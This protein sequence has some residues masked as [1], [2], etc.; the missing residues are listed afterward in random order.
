MVIEIFTVM[1]RITGLTYETANYQAI[2]L[3]TSCGFTTCE[4]ETILATKHRRRVA[5][6]A[7]LFGYMFSVVLATSIINVIMSITRYTDDGDIYS[8]FFLIFIPVFFITIFKLKRLKSKIDNLIKKIVESLFRK[9][10]LVNPFYILETY[11]DQ[12]ICELYVTHVPD[13]LAG[14][15]IFESGI[16]NKYGLTYISIN[17]K[18]EN[19]IIEPFSDIIKKNDKIVV[20]GKPSVINKVFKLSINID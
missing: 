13:E 11:G 3:L 6:W 9:K 16:K 18:N 7:M 5:K 20:Y 12:A 14:K 8:L 2:S 10:T 19:R 15:T 17:R 4:S 1:F